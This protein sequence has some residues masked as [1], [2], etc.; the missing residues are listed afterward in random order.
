MRMLLSFTLVVALLLRNLLLKLEDVFHGNWLAVVTYLAWSD[1]ALALKL[2]DQVHQLLCL[3]F[4]LRVEN[5]SRNCS[6]FKFV[7]SPAHPTFPPLGFALA[8]HNSR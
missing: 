3:V 6:C 8:A 4:L 7:F 5:Q 1:D 2:I